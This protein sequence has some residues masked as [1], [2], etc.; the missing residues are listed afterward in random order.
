MDYEARKQGLMAYCKLDELTEDEDS[1]LSAFHDSAVGYMLQ[2][3]IPE[4][5]VGS[6]AYPIYEVC[7]KHLVLD[8]WD[9]RGAAMA[10]APVE[11]PVFRRMLNQLKL[12]ASVSDSDTPEWPEVTP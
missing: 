4:P 12:T 5:D 9:H 2:A 8:S 7:L 10:A 1:L 11:N 6:P 3:G